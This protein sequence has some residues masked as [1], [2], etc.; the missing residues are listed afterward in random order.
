[1]EDAA[2]TESGT[3]L[4]V[5]SEKPAERPAGLADW[6]PLETLRRDIDQFVDDLGRSLRSMP[7]GLSGA[8]TTPFASGGLAW[9]SGPAADMVSKP[10]CYE[11]TAELPGM[12]EKN[13]EVKLS[14][15]M[16]TIRGEKRH[17][18][19]ETKEG[20]YLSERRFGAF[21][22]AFRIPQGV[23]AGRIEAVLRNGVLTVTLPKTDEATAEKTIA[24]Q[25][26]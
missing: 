7:F 26:A 8:L 23:D 3:K 21:E 5:K 2:T 19:E 15:G 1:M 16:L 4:T 17:E 10:T 20:Y 11:I 22:R 18:R 25:A 13:I 12:D 6:R 24:V 9:P 14:D